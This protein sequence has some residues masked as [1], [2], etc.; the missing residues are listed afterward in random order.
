MLLR[1]A[2]QILKKAGYRLTEGSMSLKDK[3]ANAKNYSLEADRKE[4]IDF[5][6]RDGEFKVTINAP[7]TSKN[8]MR[9]E[10][11]GDFDFWFDIDIYM[12]NG[13]KRVFS[14]INGMGEDSEDEEYTDDWVYDFWEN[15]LEDA[16]EYARESAEDED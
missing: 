16:F 4:V 15:R 10:Y 8:C 5:F 6:T 3:I 9:F 1:E 7:G 13:V 2:K 12:K 14:G 11:T